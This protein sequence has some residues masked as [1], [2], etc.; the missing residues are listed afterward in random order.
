[1]VFVLPYFVILVF[2]SSIGLYDEHFTLQLPTD[3]SVTWNKKLRK[4]AGYCISGQE[5]SGGKRYTRIELS[6][7][8]CDSAGNCLDLHGSSFFA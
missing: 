1:M 7:K 4:T 6:D 3:M 5:R 2:R 8:V